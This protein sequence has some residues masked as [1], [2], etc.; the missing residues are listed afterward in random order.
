M[1]TSGL[2]SVRGQVMHCLETGSG[3]PILF[4]HGN[5]TSSELWRNV[6]PWLADRGWC[7]APDLIGMGRSSKPDI[8]YRFADHAAFLEGLIDSLN[9]DRM[10]IVTH[11]WGVALGAD[12]VARHPDRVRAFAFMEGRLEPLP[13]WDAF[14]EGGRSLF[15]RFRTPGEGERLI[16]VENMLVEVILQAG[17][18]RALTV[19]ELDA[20][21]A[22]YPDARS[23]LPLL[24]WTRE[25]PV[26]GEPEDVAARMTAAFEALR[27]SEMPKLA[28]HAS[29]GAVI[30]PGDVARWRACLPNF[31]A[32]HVGA[33]RHF[34]P[35]DQPDAIGRTL[36][37]WTHR[38]DGFRTR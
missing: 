15:R 11:D 22:P 2:V 5:P 34:L 32:R 24:Q 4:L 26:G 30:G 19:D 25:I 3:A 16:L 12:L 6:M 29:P 20:Y 31:A 37:E 7:I 1:P 17:T 33:G 13:G 8:A 38:S 18:E 10:A 9:L 28:L 21:R 35:H 23:R 27:A 36:R 14:D